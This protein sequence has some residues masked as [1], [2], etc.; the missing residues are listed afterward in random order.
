MPTYD[1]MY[2]SGVHTYKVEAHIYLERGNFW[3]DVVTYEGDSFIGM[4]RALWEAKRTSD[5]VVL[6]IRNRE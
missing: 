3:R 4:L 1:E 2:P 5:N 6:Q